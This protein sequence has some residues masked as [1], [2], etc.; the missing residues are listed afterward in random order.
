M[1]LLPTQRLRRRLLSLN[2]LWQTHRLLRLVRPHLWNENTFL[3]RG[4]RGARCPPFVFFNNLVRLNAELDSE[5]FLPGALPL[6]FSGVID[7]LIAEIDA[8]AL[9]AASSFL[10]I[11]NLEGRSCLDVCRAQQFRVWLF[12]IQIIFLTHIHNYKIS[13]CKHI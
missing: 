6:G 5:R 8:L 1:F 4:L 9:L 2:R 13:K 10:F 7:G 11:F 12:E 3:I